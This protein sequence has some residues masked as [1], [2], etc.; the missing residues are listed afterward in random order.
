MLKKII[1]SSFLLLAISCIFL[2]SSKENTKLFT[3]CYSLEKILLRN[4]IETRRHI[5][6]NIKSISEDISRYGVSKTRGNF[7]NKLISKYKESKKSFILDIIPNEL[8]CLAGYWTENLRPGTFESIIQ[9]KSKNVI[10]EFKDLKTEVNELIN[11]MNSDY[12]NIKEEFDN[13]FN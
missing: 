2:P 13:L 8:F 11:N 4:S 10:N 12:K 5:K 6:G 3:Y 7:I 1:L 9:T